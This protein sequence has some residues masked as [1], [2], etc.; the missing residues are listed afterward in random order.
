MSED[1]KNIVAMLKELRTLCEEIHRLLGTADGQIQELDKGWKP[2]PANVFSGL[3]YMLSPRQSR[4][5]SPRHWIPQDFSRFYE[6][7]NLG[8]IRAFVSVI[9]D[10]WEKESVL[11]EPLLTAG[12]FDCDPGNTIELRKIYSYARWHLKMP[13]RRDD[14]QLVSADS[15]AWPKEPLRFLHVSTLGVP[16]MSVRDDKEL[17]SKIINPLIQGIKEAQGR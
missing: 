4:R 5:Q 11:G 13:G 1:G 14:G 16:L 12:W 6:N 8:H 3:S 17:K 7:D 9:L 10:D 15:K 2:I